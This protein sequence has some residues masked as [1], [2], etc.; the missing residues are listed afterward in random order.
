[1]L[2]GWGVGSCCCHRGLAAAAA[3]TV[4][5]WLVLRKGYVVEH[6]CSEEWRAGA[7]W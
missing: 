1:M 6:G 5:R 4:V 2:L 7:W 3:G